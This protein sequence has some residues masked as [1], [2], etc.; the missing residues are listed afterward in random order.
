MLA[1]VF[2]ATFFYSARSAQQIVGVGSPNSGTGDTVRDA[3]VKVNTNFTEIYGL[4]TNGT[5][6]LYGETNSLLNSGFLLAAGA[7]ITLTTNGNT[8]EVE[9][10][11]ADH[12]AVT[13]N[14]GTSTNLVLIG[15]ELQ[16]YPVD[17]SSADVTGLLPVDS[18][19]IGTN[20]WARLDGTNTW[21]GTNTFEG[22][23]SFPGGIVTPS[24]IATNLE[25]SAPAK[26][27]LWVDDGTDYSPLNVGANG[28]VLM[29]ASGE[30]EGVKWAA[31]TNAWIVPLT[32]QVDAVASGTGY[33]TFYSPFAV[34]VVGVKAGLKT[35]QA[36]GNLFT[37]DI[38][39]NGTSILGT[40][41]TIDNTETNSIDATTPVSISDSSI[42]SDS[43]ITIDIDDCGTG[44][45]GPVVTILYTVP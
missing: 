28:E 43:A 12:A 24:L 8:I 37:V 19:D 2:A 23:T 29:A 10:A 45:V 35:A 7:N 1:A 5:F 44:G 30:T 42:A 26:G 6:L 9:A 32:N 18:I 3:F 39:E 15:Q 14:A 11:T 34:T 25:S 41:L 20:T 21:T 16:L 17:L 40:T 22:P 38:N 33:V 27:D 13:L 36:S 31:L 4:L